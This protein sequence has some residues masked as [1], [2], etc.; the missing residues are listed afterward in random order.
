MDN[1]MT[2]F[3][4][5]VNELCDVVL[6]RRKVFE[7]DIQG[8]LGMLAV[9]VEQSICS[10]V[11]PDVFL[12]D[13]GASLHDLLNYL[14]NP[15][16]PLPLDPNEYDCADIID[17][18]RKKWET[19]CENFSFP[20]E[21][22]TKTGEWKVFDCSVPG[23]IR[24]IEV[25][26]MGGVSINFPSHISLKYAEQNVECMKDKMPPWQFKLVSAFIRSLRDKMTKT[27]LCHNNLCLD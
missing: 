25:L 26:K 14:N 3:Q 21:W 9:Y 16:R 15:D 27:G 1:S 12:N 20:N 5:R 7:P 23:D 18:A 4:N 17:K 24:A 11:L 22:K 8:D 13:N 19:V 2:T 6:K 10:Y